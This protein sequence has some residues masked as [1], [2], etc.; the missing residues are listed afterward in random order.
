MP[1]S[2]PPARWRC[3]SGN[4]RSVAPMQ[5]RECN[6]LIRRASVARGSRHEAS[7]VQ[8][9]DHHHNAFIA[10]MSHDPAM[11]EWHKKRSTNTPESV[12]S[13]Q[14]IH[15]SR[16]ITKFGC[17]GIVVTKVEDEATCRM[18]KRASIRSVGCLGQK[19][20]QSYGDAHHGRPPSAELN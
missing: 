4:S 7:P 2:L 20:Q 15:E 5:Q 14:H 1:N 17:Y 19:S 18:A 11:G 9:P 16:S 8:S 6:G 10:G 3:R 13:T 12:P